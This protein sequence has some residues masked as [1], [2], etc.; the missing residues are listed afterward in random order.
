[1]LALLHVFP[2][3]QNVVSGRSPPESEEETRCSE[4]LFVEA[5]TWLTPHHLSEDGNTA[6]ADALMVAHQRSLRPELRAPEDEK[7]PLG[8][9]PTRH[10]RAAEPQLCILFQC[11]FQRVGELLH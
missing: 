3:N 8:L 7:G 10:Q 6:C 11:K 5:Y 2:E 9:I 4:Q 1:M